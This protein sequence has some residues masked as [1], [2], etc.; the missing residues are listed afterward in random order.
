MFAFANLI[1]LIFGIPRAIYNKIASFFKDVDRLKDIQKNLAQIHNQ[2]L[3]DSLNKDER[4]TTTD[5]LRHQLGSINL[6]DVRDKKELT[7]NERK[8]YVANVAASFKL[9]ESDI[10]ELIIAQEEFIAT[11][12]TSWDQVLVG[13]GSINGLYLLLEKYEKAFLEHQD[14]IKPKD[15]FNPHAIIPEL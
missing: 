5:L 1:D 3:I 13:R 9:I 11:Q 6:K 2:Q 4:L 15:E 7:E 12:A 8:N 14:N 10:K